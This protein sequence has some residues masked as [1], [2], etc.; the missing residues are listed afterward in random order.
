[1]AVYTELGRPDAERLTRAH[2]LG[3]IVRVEPIPAGSV[4]SNFVLHAERG[5]AFARIYEEQDVDGVAYEWALLDHLGASGVPVP[6]RI[7]GPEPG[8]LRV[9]GKPTALFEVLGG[10][11]ICQ[12]RVR[13][14]HTRRVGEL[15]ARTHEA[16]RSFLIRRRGRFEPADLRARLRSVTSLAR[17]ELEGACAH[18]DAELAAMERAPP[19]IHAPTVIH[20][21]LFRDNVRWDGD[22]PL[23]IL[24]WE[25]ASDGDPVYDVAVA[26]LA[27]CYGDG[28]EPALVA[29][30]LEGY[31]SVARLEISRLPRMLRAAATRFTITRITDYHLR[32]GATQAKKDWRRFYARLLEVDRAWT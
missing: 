19:P 27:W 11:E 4:N 8:A 32:E 29:A 26:I 28:Y 31:E 7:D 5:S 17:P 18:L 20:G 9:S 6:A 15:L 13:A 10:D 30:M 16:G 14:V 1:M 25:S 22:R 24:D 3:A 21:D 23:A 2:G 12:S